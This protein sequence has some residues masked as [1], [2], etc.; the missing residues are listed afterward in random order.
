MISHAV[1]N[2]GN[3]DTD[4][5]H[6]NHVLEEKFS[7]RDVRMEVLEGRVLIALQGPR[8]M[9]I[10]QKLVRE[11]LKKMGFMT[12]ANMKMPELGI[13]AIVC[14]CGYTGEDGFEISVVPQD[15]EK[16]ADTLFQDEKLS[17]AGLGARDSLRLEAGLCLHGNDMS[18]EITP[19][20]AVLLWT[21]RKENI[22]VPYIGQE[23]LDQMRKDKSH[24][25][26]RIGFEVTGSGIAR[27]GYTIFDAKDGKEIGKVTSGTYTP[28]GRALGMGYVLKKRSKE[29]RPLQ[30][31]IRK[32]LV[33]AVIK[34][35]PFIEPGY[36]RVP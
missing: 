7:G 17:P 11:D 35:P 23:V 14:R 25:Q 36:Y 27:P 22:A 15:A 5:A 19:L 1:I 16:L 6:F 26:R 33:D 28:D 8:A 31:Q 29:G 24:R 10:L 4:L 18:Q 2:A 12:I 34:K 3:T 32:K 20:E 30:I 9:D 13:E 21:V